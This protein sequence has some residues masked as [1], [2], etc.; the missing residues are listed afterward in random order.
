MDADDVPD[1]FHDLALIHSNDE[2]M[3]IMDVDRETVRRWRKRTGLHRP[4]GV[5]TL[6]PSNLQDDGRTLKDLC[7]HHGWGSYEAFMKAVRES[8][9]HVYRWARLNGI[10]KRGE[11]LRR[12]WD[13]ARG[14]G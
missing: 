2:L 14:R 3:R 13:G 12:Y 9:P 1:L 10:A 11:T 5:R 7:R 8:R 6:P 4:R